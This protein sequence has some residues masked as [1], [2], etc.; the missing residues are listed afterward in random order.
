M[1]RLSYGREMS[2]EKNMNQTLS[3]LVIV[4]VLIAILFFSV[5]SSI[6]HFKGEGS[7]CGGGGRDVKTKPKKLTKVSC[8]KV[9]EIEGMHC[10][11][12]YA[13]VHNVLN[14]IAGVSAKVEGR[15]G[16]AVIRFE[17][18]PDDEMIKGA[19]EELGYTV[20]SMKEKC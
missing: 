7:C 14:S 16:R 6:A 2:E 12:C 9:V 10:E 1:Y 18:D 8:V 5:K 19:I 15:K 13:R 17:N 3:N 4:A 11:H 20:V